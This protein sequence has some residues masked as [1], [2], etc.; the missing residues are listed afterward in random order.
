MAVAGCPAFA[1][2]TRQTLEIDADWTFQLGSRSAEVSAIDPTGWRNVNLPHT[3]NAVDGDDG[4]NY[5]R[6]PAFYR[7]TVFQPARSA[8]TRTFIEFD[9]AAVVTDLWVNGTYVGQ[10]K[11]GYARFRFDLTPYLRPGENQLLVRTDNSASLQVAPLGGDFTVYGGIYRS[12]RLIRTHDVHFDM[13]D[14]GS[15]GIEIRQSEVTAKQ[16]KLAYRVRVANDGQVDRAVRVRVNLRNGNATVLSLETSLSVQAGAVAVAD[17][18]GELASPHLWN[19]VADPHLYQSEISVENYAHER[20]DSA[21][22]AT[23]LRS[24]LIRPDQGVLLNGRPYSV[25]GV[26][27][28][29]TMLPERGTAVT[30]GNIDSDFRLLKDLGVTGL[31]F[32]HYQHPQR[33]YD[34]ADE[35]GILVWTEVPFVAKASPDEGFEANLQDQLRELIRQNRNHPSVFVWGLGNE[36]YSVD[37]DSARL[38]DGLQA[39]AHKEDPDRPTTYANCCAPIDGPQASHTDTIGSNVYYGWYDGQFDD[40]GPWLDANH[41]KRPATPEAVSE[42]GAGGSPYHQADP[43]SRPRPGSHW[44]PEQYQAL[45]HERAWS[46]I[47]QRPWLWAS[48]IWCGFDFP[49]DGRNEGDRSGINDKGLITYDR[50]IRKD[51]YFWYKANWT[52]SPMVYITSR[53]AVTRHTADVAVKVYG[54]VSQARLRLNGRDLGAQPFENHMATWN[55]RLSPG[56]NTLTVEGG[57][58]VDIVTWV[59]TAE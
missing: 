16:A 18:A 19:G 44:H 4:G 10:H 43:P 45:Y 2:E 50:R 11:G 34:L 9:G 17:L 55:V 24:I 33:G 41:V 31:R 7:K 5:H 13:L 42:Y 39:L 12:V 21:T 23:G 53:R 37:A 3:Y 47:A 14:Y 49:S 54:N 56:K 32:A 27:I 59:L 51:A 25:H 20:L 1:Y 15:S 38:L 22:V 30:D 36:I 46:Q 29:Q 48:F 28:H 8:F 57:S 26:N 52:S 58:A 6:G 35:S 40:L